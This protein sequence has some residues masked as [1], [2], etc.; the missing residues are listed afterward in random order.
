V[1]VPEV[2]LHGETGFVVPPGDL[3]GMWAAVARV[4]QIDPLAC[5]ARVEAHFSGARMVAGYGELFERLTGRL[6]LP[7]S[8]MGGSRP[9][10]RR[11]SSRRPEAD[12]RVGQ[13]GS[14]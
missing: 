6:G 3:N 12:G 10:R 8:P 7:P 1:S 4:A 14:V 11:W 5:R 2:V 13:A 9:W